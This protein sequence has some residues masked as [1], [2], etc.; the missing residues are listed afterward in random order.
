V[1]S[2]KDPPSSPRFGVGY[3]ETLCG[4]KYL[5]NDKGEAKAFLNKRNL[6]SY[7]AN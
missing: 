2:A 4:E 7:L 6:N 5:A 3:R 1:L